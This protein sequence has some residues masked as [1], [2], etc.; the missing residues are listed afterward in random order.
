MSSSFL[1]R[2]IFSFF[3]F[4]SSSLFPF[5]LASSAKLRHLISDTVTPNDT[6]FPTQTYLGSPATN[7]GGLNAHNA[8]KLSKGSSVQPVAV[9]SVGCGSSAGR[10]GDELPYPRIQSVSLPE[11]SA[12]SPTDGLASLIAGATNNGI[13]VAGICWECVVL[14]VAVSD[15]VTVATANSLSRGLQIVIDNHIRIAVI[16]LSIITFDPT[17]I[18]ELSAAIDRARLAGVLVISG[19]GQPRQGETPC[20]VD[21]MKCIN[22]D[23]HPLG[24]YPAKLNADNLL[25]VG[26]FQGDNLSNFS[27]ISVDI[28]TGSHEVPQLVD[29]VGTPVKT[30]PEFSAAM[31]GAVVS[32]IW[33]MRPCWGYRQIKD[34]II[35]TACS[36]VDPA[37]SRVGPVI[38]FGSRC[39]GTLDMYKAVSYAKHHTCQP[40]TQ[41]SP[42]QWIG[43][44]Y[45]QVST[46]QSFAYTTP[47][48]AA[49]TGKSCSPIIK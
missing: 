42:L 9:L 38:S 36:C 19:P 6:L 8:W 20:N 49:T 2:C 27:D 10:S 18:E 12:L 7:F 4:S 26:Q 1:F 17:E 14:C 22:K 21:T 47:P 45:S 30:P 29:L 28:F 11:L 13:G 3:L 23:H 15:S 16:G 33:G 41:P 34:I 37:A 39:G 31:A 43:N 40:R 48:V 5:S 32:V 24:N 25:V 46:L 35:N 44:F